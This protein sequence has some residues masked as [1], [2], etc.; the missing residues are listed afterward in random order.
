MKETL[1]HAEEKMQKS[2]KAD[3]IELIQRK[4]ILTLGVTELKMKKRIFMTIAMTMKI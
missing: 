2:L 3:S 1:K 4:T